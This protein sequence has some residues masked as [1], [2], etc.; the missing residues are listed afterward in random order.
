MRLFTYKTLTCKC[1]CLPYNTLHLVSTLRLTN[2]E[3]ALSTSVKHVSFL[4]ISGCPAVH[5]GV[6]C[7][8]PTPVNLSRSISCSSAFETVL[9]SQT[10]IN[11]SNDGETKTK[12]KA[13]NLCICVI[14]IEL[15]QEKGYSDIFLSFWILIPCWDYLWQMEETYFV[16]KLSASFIVSCEYRRVKIRKNNLHKRKALFKVWIK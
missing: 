16:T 14:D 3:L 9:D 2:N 6:L 13:L 8:P 11:L 15:W 10:T 1:E 12:F 5:D 7:W 4:P